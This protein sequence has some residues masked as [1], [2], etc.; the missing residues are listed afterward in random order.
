MSDEIPVVGAFCYED[1]IIIE[2][3]RTRLAAAE[4]RA[5]EAERVLANERAV[6]IAV[7]RRAEA[8]EARLRE[9]SEALE[10]FVAQDG[11]DCGHP[12]CNRCERTREARRALAATSSAPA[13]SQGAIG[14]AFVSTLRE[15]GASDRVVAAAEEAAKGKP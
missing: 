8:A 6:M 2:R 13:S 12:A 11:C 7:V 9:V 1:S 4:R 5:E 10:E 15:L 14:E 3:L